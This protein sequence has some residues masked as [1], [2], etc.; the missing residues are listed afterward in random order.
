MEKSSRER[1]ALKWRRR[2]GAAAAAAAGGE[3]RRRRWREREELI[4]ARL[5]DLDLSSA[6]DEL[7]FMRFGGFLEER[8]EKTLCKPSQGHEILL[9]DEEGV[10]GNFVSEV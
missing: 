8:E 10:F 7:L 5:E 4:R 2:E 1:P 9:G 3:W 6:I